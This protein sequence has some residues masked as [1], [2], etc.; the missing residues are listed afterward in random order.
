MEP[1]R[2]FE[3]VTKVEN[4]PG[5]QHWQNYSAEDWAKFLEQLFPSFKGNLTNAA[6]LLMSF[7][8][9]IE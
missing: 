5:I 8:S 2:I 6:N 1:N 3:L 7:T 4:A 9:G